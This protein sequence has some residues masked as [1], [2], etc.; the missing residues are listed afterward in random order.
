V[1]E[2]CECENT[3]PLEGIGLDNI[4]QIGGP[5]CEECGNDL[6]VL[7]LCEVEI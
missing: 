5:I 6:P 2:S 3:I 7:S 4:L 1:C